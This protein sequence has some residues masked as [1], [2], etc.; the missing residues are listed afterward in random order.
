RNRLGF[1]EA[2]AEML[3]RDARPCAVVMIELGL[4]SAVNDALGHAWGDRVVVGAGE[5]LCRTLADQ[6]L[7]ARL[8]GDTFAV[9]LTSIGQQLG[10]RFQLVTQF[11]QAL[12]TGQVDVHFQPQLA[13]PTRQV[14]G[15]EALVRWQHPEF[16]MLDPAEFVTLVE[17]TGLI[18]PL[19]DYVLNRS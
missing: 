3:G 15:V 13:L 14:V 1:C 4:Q 18:D 11:R 10:R 17:T 12:D 6:A 19:T 7:T 5:R 16:G 2:A 9:L 8:E